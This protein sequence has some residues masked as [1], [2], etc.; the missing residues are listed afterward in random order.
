MADKTYVTTVA[1]VRVYN[2]DRSQVVDLLQRGATVP[3]D[4]DP[5]HLKM[6]LDRGLVAEGEST[7]GLDVDA[8]AAPPFTAP[9][10][11]EEHSRSRRTPQKA[12]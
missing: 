9:E 2:S 3:A 1:G 12:D 4:A 8:D 7:G 10:G 6:L 11:S 5:E